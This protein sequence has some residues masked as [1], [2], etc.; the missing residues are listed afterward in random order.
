M[1]C[2]TM[3][4]RNEAHVIRRSLLSALALVDCVC[5]CDTGSEDGTPELVCD[6]LAQSPRKVYVGS[7]SWVDF[8][9]NRTRALR[10]AEDKFDLGPQDY[11]LILDAD[12]V[13]DGGF[14]HGVKLDQDCYHLKVQDGSTV[15]HRA[16]LLRADGL[17]CYRSPVHEAPYRMGGLDATVGQLDWPVYHRIGGGARSKDP[18]K[19]RND[20]TMLLNELLN[21]PD[22]DLAP[23]WMFYMAQSYFDAASMEYRDTEKNRLL[24]LAASAYRKRMAMSGGWSQE[25]YICCLRLAE[26]GGGEDPRFAGLR[27]LKYKN[28]SSVEISTDPIKVFREPYRYKDAFEID[29]TRAEA[30]FWWAKELAAAGDNAQSLVWATYAANLTPPDGAL[31]SQTEVYD[32][33]KNLAAEMLLLLKLREGVTLR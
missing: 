3:I 9:T 32:W 11:H 20:A 7:H 23:R 21:N 8:G 4:V 6:L 26:I 24:E 27:R 29:P 16:H 22:S 12:D 19:F 5:V 14:E 33:A 2:L 1:I 15:Y 30:P 18:D 31:F 25:R 17:W 13:L 10:T 28:T